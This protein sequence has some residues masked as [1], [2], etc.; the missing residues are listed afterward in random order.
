MKPPKIYF[1]P[2]MGANKD[3]FVNQK[4]AG[5]EMEV[6]EWIT[7]YDQESIE[8]YSERLAESINSNEEFILAGVSFGGIIAVEIAKKLNPLKTILISSV[9]TYQEYPLLLKLFSCIPIYKMTP[10]SAYS[11]TFVQ[12]FILYSMGL[13]TYEGKKI[14]LDML[15]N[16]HVQFIQWSINALMK[17]RNTTLP[18]SLVRIHGKYD[19]VFPISNIKDAHFI[20]GGHSIILEDAERVNSII[21]SVIKN[22]TVKDYTKTYLSKKSAD[23]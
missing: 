7:P 23:F 15:K 22:T 14:F 1:I 5:F 9:P 8:N 17:W 20:P 12:K 2:G 16:S 11:N 21:G 13:Q 4:T 10:E 3:L 19:R 6:L 18:S